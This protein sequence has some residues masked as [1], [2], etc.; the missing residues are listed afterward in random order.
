MSIL[1]E[2]LQDLINA[3]QHNRIL[4]LAFPNNDGPKCELGINRLHAVESMSRDFTF[5]VELLSDKA[6]LALKDMQGKLLSVALVQANGSLRY[7]S[8]YCFTFRL[9]KAANVSVYEATLGPWLRYL[10]IGKDNYLF[11]NKTLREQT[12]SIFSDYAIHADWDLRLLGDDP[13]MTDAMQFGESDHNYLH[14]RWEAAGWH[15]YYTH[16]DRGHQLVL[17]D[18]STAANPI[19]GDPNI[20][21]HRHG[22]SVE[23][24]AISAWTS[25]RQIMPCSV[26]L[27]GFNFKD[28]VAR[29]IGVPTTNQQGIVA[30]TEWYE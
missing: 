20:R 19:D 26:M 4:R 17:A 11:H 27:A 24:E 2:R 10:A 3:R 7:F 16:T 9:K 30:Q 8:G 5:T 12:E 18:D 6:N 14:R 21:F 13:A 28:P 1:I 25:T 22:G 23:E 15:Y 29:H